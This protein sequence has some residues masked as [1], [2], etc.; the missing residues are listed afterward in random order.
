MRIY[1]QDLR[2]R[3]LGALERGERPM[4]IVRRLEVSWMRVYQ[5]RRRWQRDGSRESLRQGVSGFQSAETLGVTPKLIAHL[6]TH[7]SVI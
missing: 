2:D 3:V 6:L 5:V 4:E 1:S 7:Q